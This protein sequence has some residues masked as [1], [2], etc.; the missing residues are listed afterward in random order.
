MAKRLKSLGIGRVG[1]KIR[2]KSALLW[3]PFSLWKTHAVTVGFAPNRYRRSQ[4]GC[5]VLSWPS[6]APQWG[7]YRPSSA[8]AVSGVLSGAPPQNLNRGPV[9][10]ACPTPLPADEVRTVQP[11][12]SPPGLTVR[13]LTHNCQLTDRNAH[14]LAHRQGAKY[15]EY[16]ITALGHL[17]EYIRPARIPVAGVPSERCWRPLD[18]AGQRCYAGIGNNYPLWPRGAVPARAATAGVALLCLWPL[19]S[20]RHPAMPG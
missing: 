20:L 2:F 3:G 6:D 11:G 7:C 10:P 1:S 14:G 15:I 17:G 13:K 16:D 12:Q 9:P 5:S 8:K 4:G 19:F 18:F